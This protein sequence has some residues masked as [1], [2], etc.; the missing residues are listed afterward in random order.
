[1]KASEVKTPADWIEYQ[2]EMLR[3]CHN[4]ELE[5]LGQIKMLLEKLTEMERKLTETDDE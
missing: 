1:M 4:R 5:L 2:H 3:E